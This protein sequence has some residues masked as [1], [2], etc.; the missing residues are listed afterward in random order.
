MK[1]FIGFI[2]SLKGFWKLY[3][4]Y[5]Y[6]GEVLR[7]IIE[8]YTSVICNRTKT[9]SKPTYYLYDVLS[10]ID[11]YYEDVYEEEIKKIEFLEERH[12]YLRTRCMESARDS[13]DKGLYGA[14]T[15][16]KDVK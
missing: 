4:D 12:K 16:V 13:F 2:K 3:C 11:R 5:E 10:E 9:M 8:T 6:D 14:L 15:I 7:H 1:T